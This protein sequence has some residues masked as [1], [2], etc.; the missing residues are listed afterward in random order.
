[1]LEFVTGYHSHSEEFRRRLASD[2]MSS[3]S[4][5][6]RSPRL[7]FPPDDTLA[8]IGNRLNQFKSD[9]GMI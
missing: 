4:A 8:G 3:G 9:S 7:M 5:L 2:C 6:S 1:M